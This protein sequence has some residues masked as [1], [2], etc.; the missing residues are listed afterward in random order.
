[1]QEQ[2]QAAP[3]SGGRV[4]S[5]GSSRNV[6]SIFISDVHLGFPGCSA[7]YLCDFLQQTRCTNL[8]LVGDIVDFWHL[9]RRRHWPEAHSRVLRRIFRM[10]DA[11]TRVVLVPGNHDACVAA[12]WDRTF[13]LWRDYMASDEDG[14][15]ASRSPFPSLRI[16]GDIAFIGL[17]SAC[18][19][20]PLMATGTIGKEQLS[21]LPALLRAGRL[22]YDE[23]AIDL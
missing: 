23:T 16:R 3:R 8:Y 22:R 5:I 11:G 19:K 1:M 17:S 6:N 9:R 18:P 7:D 15:E 4:T 2:I 12:P 13:A 10:A 21:R 20:P 14:G